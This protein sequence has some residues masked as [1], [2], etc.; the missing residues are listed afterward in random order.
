MTLV[1]MARRR[2]R[3]RGELDA[4]VRRAV[5]VAVAIFG[6][7]LLS[8]LMLVIAMVIRMDTPGPALFRQV[9]VGRQGQHFRLY[10]FRKF[11]DGPNF[12]G[13]AV[14]L[15]DDPR[16]TRVGRVLER[17]KLD[18]MPQLWNIL[19]GDMSLVGPRPETL[20]FADC[21]DDRLQALLDYRP[22]LFGPS[23]AIFRNESALYPAGRDPH[24]F[25]RTVLFPA[26]AEI[27]F[28]YFRERTMMSD[29]VWIIR[30]V[31]AVAGLPLSVAQGLEGVDAINTPR[32]QPRPASSDVD[33]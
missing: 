20:H 32:L 11:A 27:D 3:R 7:A 4:V 22:G 24:D 16:M 2:A 12:A 9:R 28:R 23:Q 6:L 30:G 10:K 21:F 18:E 5:D 8:P 1:L 14:T 19:I 26:K 25:Y 29:L 31:L 33:D 13:P 17:T 15:K